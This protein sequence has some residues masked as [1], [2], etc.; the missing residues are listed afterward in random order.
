[1]SPKERF[2]FYMKHLFNCNLAPD[3]SSGAVCFECQTLYQLVELLEI[4]KNEKAMM[5]ICEDRLNP[6]K[7]QRPTA[8]ASVGQVE[9][10]MKLLG[11]F[12][13]SVARISS[14]TNAVHIGVKIDKDTSAMSGFTAQLQKASIVKSEPHAFADRCGKSTL[15]T[16]ISNLKTIN[17]LV[18]LCIKHPDIDIMINTVSGSRLY[19][20][21]NTLPSKCLSVPY[22]WAFCGSTQI[23]D[24]YGWMSITHIIPTWK[25]LYNMRYMNVMFVVKGA[26]ISPETKVNT[27]PEFL[28]SEYN[29]TCGKAYEA[30]RSNMKLVIPTD[31][32]LAVGIGYCAK[33][34]AA[35]L[36]MSVELKINGI[37][38][39]I[40][41]LT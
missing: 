29:R 10:A 19:L 21:D 41:R 25:S 30:L 31:E 39:T 38:V 32:P 23:W 11:D 6:H 18:E 13:I 8:E 26:K 15:S 17:E 1:M 28:S 40:S 14:H 4:A 2:E 35:K 16:E 33:D 22:T 36:N 37:A 20:A 24:M 34:E 3:I 27:F 12:T 5:S 7:Y 9:V